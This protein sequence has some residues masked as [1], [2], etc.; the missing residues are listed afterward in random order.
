M[1]KQKQIKLFVGSVFAA[2]TLTLLLLMQPKPAKAVVAS[3][4][5]Y[6]GSYTS[7]SHHSNNLIY[8]CEVPQTSSYA[9]HLGMKID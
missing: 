3:Y 1:N 4:C 5:Q 2:S 7:S 9:Y 6:T 8:R